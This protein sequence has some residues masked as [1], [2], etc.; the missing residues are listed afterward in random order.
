MQGS[1]G[2]EL[3]PRERPAAGG[4]GNGGRAREAAGAGTAGAGTTGA[5]TAGGWER[6][7]CS[8]W[9]EGGSGGILLR[10][11]ELTAGMAKDAGA[12]CSL[13]SPPRLSRRRM[14]QRGDQ[15]GVQFISEGPAAVMGRTHGR[16]EQ[17]L[18]NE[19]AP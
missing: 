11:P 17:S 13:L 15:I 9:V 18:L 4:T 10:S 3:S 6:P 2:R 12:L 16:A 5:G 8:C 7:L 1:G 14:P 19:G